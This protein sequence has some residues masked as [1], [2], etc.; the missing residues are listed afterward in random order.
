MLHVKKPKSD[1]AEQGDEGQ[2][3]QQK[4]WP[5][6]EGPYHYVGQYNPEIV[7][8][9]HLHVLAP[10]VEMGSRIPARD[11]EVVNRGNDESNNRKPEYPVPQFL[12][13]TSIDVFVERHG[14]DIADLPDLQLPR[15]PVVEI[16]DFRPVFVRNNAEYAADGADD[17]VQLLRPK[18]RLMAA[19]VLN[20][21]NADQEKGVDKEERDAQPYRVLHRKVQQN[22]KGDK[23]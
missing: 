7:F 17:I 16:V 1:D 11:E 9:H 14:G 21:K 3:D 6:D 2:L 5:T 22:P 20:D 13:P 23:R 18:E 4:H 19:I 12:P 8:E 10:F 15:M